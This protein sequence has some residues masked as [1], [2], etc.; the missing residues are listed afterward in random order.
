MRTQSVT[1]QL[2]FQ[3]LGKRSVTASFDGGTITSDA[4]A[5]LLRAVETTRGIISKFADCFIDLRNQRYVEHSLWSLIA[6]RVYGLCLGYEDV[7]DHERLREDP[8]IATLCEQPDVEGRERRHKRDR[9]KPLAGK[10]TLNRLETAVPNLTSRYKKIGWDQSA[11]A[12]CFV[13][14]FLSSFE[15][16]PQHIVLD[17]DDTDDPLHGHQEGRFFHGYY[18]CYCYLPLYVFCGDHLLCA[19]LREA[20]GGESNDARQ[21]LHRIVAQIRACWPQVQILVRADSGFCTDELM[22]WCE[23]NEVEYVLGLARNK[24]LLRRL[25]RDLD[26]AGRQ[27]Q[28]TGQ[29]VRR[30]KDFT[31]RTLKSWSRRRRVVGKAEFLAKG[32]NP[33]FVVTSL[34]KKTIDAQQLYEQTYCARGEMENRIKEQQLYLFADRTSSHTMHANQLRLWF[35]SIAYL[36]L[37]ELRRRALHD[38]ELATAQCDTIR[39]KLLKIGAQVHISVR[40]IVLRLAS[41]YPYQQVFCQAYANLTRAGP[42]PA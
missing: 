26:I 36:L 42:Q 25:Q 5:L 20:S 2:S 12:R 6:Q 19:K 14:V 17:L 32:A 15:K 35:S 41:S 24:R 22:S 7:V 23:R 4:G 10:S 21:E 34:S 39:L 29:P 8:L 37:S 38:T 40:R 13:D 18:D 28:R 1:K 33:R 31:Y 9:G 16:P 11:I 3:G 27:Y 30:F